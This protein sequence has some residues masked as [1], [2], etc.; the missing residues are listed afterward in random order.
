MLSK[1]NKDSHKGKCCGRTNGF[2]LDQNTCECC[3][4]KDNVEKI[5]KQLEEDLQNAMAHHTKGLQAIRNHHK[6]RHRQ[7]ELTKI[8]LSKDLFEKKALVD[9][10]DRDHCTKKNEVA[11]KLISEI[12]EALR[13]EP[14]SELKGLNNI[15]QRELKDAIDELE[16]Q[17][18][19]EETNSQDQNL[20]RVVN[21]L[22]RMVMDS[23]SKNDWLKQQL[24]QL[25]QK[26]PNKEI[27]SADCQKLRCKDCSTDPKILAQEMELHQMIARLWTKLSKSEQSEQRDGGSPS[28]FSMFPPS[29][30]KSLEAIIGSK[31]QEDPMPESAPESHQKS[32]AKPCEMRV[33]T[34]EKVVYKRD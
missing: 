33:F 16:K 19:S 18:M 11:D 17:K 29:L 8:Q 5:E 23:Q 31:C 25:N 13:S 2:N 6:E 1:E 22:E 3:N 24:L 30:I 7:L 27:S 28:V 12:D 4:D 15:L 9:D 21:K 34:K 14:I 26:Q 10:F 32:Q 20:N